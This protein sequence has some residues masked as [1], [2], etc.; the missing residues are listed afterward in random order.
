[1]AGKE[2]REEEEEEEDE[3]R[4]NVGNPRLGCMRK[5]RK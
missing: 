4:R 3:E 1:M 5:E 2:E